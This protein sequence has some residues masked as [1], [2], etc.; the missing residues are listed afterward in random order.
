MGISNLTGKCLSDIKKSILS[1]HG[2]D[3]NCLKDFDHFDILPSAGNKFRL[4]I[5]ES[6]KGKRD[7]P[8]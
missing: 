6:L 5:K 4:L 1:D 7:Q 2:L 8:S 3:S